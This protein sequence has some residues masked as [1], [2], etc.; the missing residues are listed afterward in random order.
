M[1]KLFFVIATAMLVFTACKE[2]YDDSALW[3]QMNEFEMRLVELERMCQEMN[4]N[5]SS[6]QGIVAALQTGDWITSV[7]PIVED[8]KE[9]GYKIS[10]A[11]GD[12]IIIYHGADGADGVN[13]ANGVD[14]ATPTIGVKMDTDGIYYWT[15]NGEWLLDDA[16]NKIKAVGTDGENGDQGE[17]GPAGE[18]GADGTDGKDGITPQLKIENGCWFVS[19]DNGATWTNLGKATGEDGKD[20]ADG[21]PGQDGTN[22]ADG[23]DG[24]SMF[25]SVEETDT[26]VIFVLADGTTITI[27]K[28]AKL[29][30]T[31][32]GEGEI[33]CMA[34]KSV[35]IDFTVTPASMKPAIET[36]GENGWKTKVAMSS[37]SAGYL[38][39]SAPDPIVDGKVLV[40]I[41]DNCGH[42]AMK[43]LHFVEGLFTMTTD[44]YS[45]AADAATFEVQ[46]TTNID[47][48]VEI[49]TAAQSWLSVAAATRA[50]VRTDKLQVSVAENPE[51]SPARTGDIRLLNSAGEAV[52]TITVTQ[53]A[54]PT[55]DP[56]TFADPVVKEFLVD[57]YD[58][59][60]DGEISYKEAAAVT[61]FTTNF[62]VI[63]TSFDELQ[64]FTGITSLSGFE[65]CSNLKS[66]VISDG[67]TKI[68]V[69]AFRNCSSL[70]SGTIPDS[71]TEIVGYAFYGCSSLTSVTI[72]DS[73]T[74][75][76]NNVFYDCKNLH[77][78]CKALVPPTLGS[79][80]LSNS[81]T[82]F[83]GIY[84]P[85]ES[86]D[87][88]KAAEGWSKYADK[89]VG[90]DFE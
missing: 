25:S 30:I 13:G 53:Q 50:E 3:K 84:V 19:T 4:S 62:P 15:L 39:V 63:I 1:K 5:I 72:P 14:G 51:D 89:I 52:Q 17:Q 29:D 32:S 83:A 58:T 71:V 8:G 78:Y 33:A 34:G 86:V 6:L 36:I 22:G 45:V 37:D 38:L 42:T 7:T 28:A 12:A 73:V 80:G 68:G 20:G 77:V 65:G 54:R 2:D 81:S 40:F 56:I 67:V 60:G 24:D 21:A 75:I 18:N 88:Y 9:V 16:G 49:D 87:A 90:Y 11:V 55:A 10:F 69:Y 26:E 76:G 31:F 59:N 66:V 85:T 27:P 44:A 47:Y 61:E 41:S 64:Y 79:R 23:K 57:N 48:T 74:K 35:R 82:G 46:V 43:S 70:T